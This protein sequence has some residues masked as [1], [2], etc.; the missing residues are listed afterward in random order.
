V[1]TRWIGLS[2]HG[3]GIHGT[4]APGSIGKNASHG[5]IRLRNADVEQLFKLVAVGDEVEIFG[6]Q[7]IEVVAIGAATVRER[8][9]NS[10]V[11]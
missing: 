6:E 10:G 2:E 1:G 4:N 8:S 11:N 5:C 9:L 3:Y 7:S